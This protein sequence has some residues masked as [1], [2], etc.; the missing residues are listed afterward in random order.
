MESEEFEQIPWAN[1]VAEQNDGIDKRIYM[2]VGVVGLLVVAV[3]AMRLV[4]GGSQPMPPDAPI[5]SPPTS[6]VTAEDASTPPTSMVIAEADLRVEE[7][8]AP[9]TADRLVEVTAEWFVTDW[10][11]RDGSDE[12]IRSIRSALD[13]SLA[14]DPLPH[15]SEEEPVTFVEWAKTVSLQATA[16]GIDATVAYRVIRETDEG[17]VREPVATVVVGLLRDGNEVSVAYL[18]IADS[19]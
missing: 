14:A 1:L 2:A 12:T 16:D 5:A 17:F 18:P 7:A 6:T 19:R 10:F 9:E 11:T 3:F 8:A 15:E 13:P 4:G